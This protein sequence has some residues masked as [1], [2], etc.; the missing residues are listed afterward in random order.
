MAWQRQFVPSGLNA[1]DSAA[2]V[3]TRVISL[4]SR[5]VPGT[6]CEQQGH[7][8]EL[9][10]QA[11]DLMR[12]LE[13]QAFDLQSRAHR[14]GEDAIKRLQNAQAHIDLLE[15]ERDKAEA[16]ANE[17]FLRLRELEKAFERSASQLVS[18]EARL[19]EAERRASVADE[20]SQKAEKMLV[21]VEN[22][23]RNRLL[24][25]QAEPATKNTAA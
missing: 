8:I 5:S 20:R 13:Q 23:I 4:R 7:A 25:Q 17:A 16:A 21:A 15:A 12:T 22:A 24:R 11:A 10:E 2:E 18:A 9:I 14:I 3:D 1:S 6:E 19:F